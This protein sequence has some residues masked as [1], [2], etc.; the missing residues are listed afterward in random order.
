MGS[1]HFQRQTRRHKQN[2][3]GDCGDLLM[4]KT[5]F[6][7]KTTSQGIVRD[8]SEPYL[9][10]HKNGPAFSSLKRLEKVFRRGVYI[11]IFQN[12]ICQPQSQAINQNRR[13]LLDL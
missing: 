12:E 6:I 3:S 2:F 4:K 1:F 8:N 5:R 13:T 10:T 11:T 9:V 7:A